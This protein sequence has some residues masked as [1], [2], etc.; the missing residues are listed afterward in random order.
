MTALGRENIANLA[1]KLGYT[2]K[3]Q[4]ARLKEIATGGIEA[5][6]EELVQLCAVASG[7]ILRYDEKADAVV[8]DALNALR[9]ALFGRNLPQ[10]QEASGIPMFKLESFRN[11]AD[12]MSAEQLDELILHLFPGAKVDHEA[13]TLVPRGYIEVPEAD[14]EINRNPHL[15]ILN[16]DTPPRVDPSLKSNAV[17]VSIGVFPPVAQGSERL[18]G[19]IVVLKQETRGAWLQRLAA[20][21]S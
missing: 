11:G 12:G 9:G 2:R 20:K 13:S 5:T 4:V 6:T 15:R 18:D 1:E 21:A 3:H 10:L 14:F 16:P 7:N 8:T 19:S 17:P